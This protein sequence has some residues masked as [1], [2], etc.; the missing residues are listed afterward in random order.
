MMIDL[1]GGEEQDKL[2]GYDRGGSSD[3]ARS[4]WVTA[5]RKEEVMEGIAQ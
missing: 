1:L 2:H 5:F 4:V 3:T